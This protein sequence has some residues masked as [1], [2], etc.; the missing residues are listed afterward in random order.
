M[1]KTRL[2]KPGR[3][4]ELTANQF[5]NGVERYFA[6]ITSEE[7]VTQDVPDELVDMDGTIIRRLDEKGHAI[8]K[9]VKVL[10]MN[11]EP[12]KRTVWVCPPGLAALCLFLGIDKATFARYAKLESSSTVS[13]DD[14]QLYRASAAWAKACM[15]A[16]LEE[17]LG[18]KNYRGAMFNLQENYGWKQKTEV[19]VRGGVEEFLKN[20]GQEV[21]F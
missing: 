16:Y 13:Q 7:E 17:Q 19:T 14:A 20:F 21:S 1:K 10:D 5:R 12:V 6:S 4:K 9:R 11:G 18:G 8:K 3:P 15:E 2:G